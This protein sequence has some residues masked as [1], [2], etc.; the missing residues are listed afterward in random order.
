[1]N[2]VSRFE[3]TRVRCDLVAPNAP[4]EESAELIERT[5]GQVFVLRH[6]NA[7]PLN[8]IQQLSADCFRAERADCSRAR[9]QRDSRL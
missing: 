4:D 9:Q 2:Y 7:D 5:G 6:R 3:A 1:M 8:Y